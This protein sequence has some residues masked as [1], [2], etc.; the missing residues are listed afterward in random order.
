[1]KQEI[2]YKEIIEWAVR[3]AAKESNSINVEPIWTVVDSNW[4]Q[5]EPI[6]HWLFWKWAILIKK[7]NRKFAKA[8]QEYCDDNNIFCSYSDYHRALFVWACKSYEYERMQIFYNEMRYYLIW[9]W[10][11]S[12]LITISVELD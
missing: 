5:Y 9:C 12:K 1:M 10:I 4:K 6:S 8:L 3:Y 7:Q 2:N 11:D